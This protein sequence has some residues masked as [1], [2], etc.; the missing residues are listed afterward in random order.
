MHYL[1]LTGEPWRTALAF[2]HP[3]V[4]IGRLSEVKSE[5]A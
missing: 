4:M 1:D 3:V 5:S 2:D